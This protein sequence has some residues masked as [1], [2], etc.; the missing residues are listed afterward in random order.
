[1][2]LVITVLWVQAVGTKGTCAWNN[3]LNSGST[4][5]HAGRFTPQACHQ[6]HQSCCVVVSAGQQIVLFCHYI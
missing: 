5:D 4:E 2:S 1:M 6:Y 3:V